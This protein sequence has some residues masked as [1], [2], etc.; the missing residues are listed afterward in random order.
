MVNTSS[1]YLNC[2]KDFLATAYQ[3]LLDTIYFVL[4]DIS[5]VPCIT[6][7]GTAVAKSLQHVFENSGCAAKRAEAFLVF[8]ARSFEWRPRAI[9]DALERGDWIHLPNADQ[10]P[11][12]IQDRLNPLLERPA[13][14]L[15]S[16]S[17]RLDLRNNC[18][19]LSVAEAPPNADG[20]AVVVLPHPDSRVFMKVTAH[21][22]KVCD[23]LSKAVVQPSSRNMSERCSRLCR[24]VCGTC[25]VWSFSKWLDSNSRVG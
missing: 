7:H 21:G 23:G 15:C 1:A 8:R 25:G 20:S 11:A 4:Q 14:K 6:G 5:L 2:P 19:A 12:A 24:S 18:G 17:D 3:N 22:S 9:V 16:D 10:Y 13:V